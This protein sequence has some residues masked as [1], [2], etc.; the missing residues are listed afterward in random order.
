MKNYQSL[1]IKCLPLVRNLAFKMSYG[2][3]SLQDELICVGNEALCIAAMRFDDSKASFATYAYRCIEGSMLNAINTERKYESFD[4]LDD[5]KESN[6]NTMVYNSADRYACKQYLD[7]APGSWQVVD[8]LFNRA[9]LTE[10]EDDVLRSYY[11]VGR[12]K[13]STKDIANRYHRTVQ[14]VNVYRRNAEAKLRR[15][16]L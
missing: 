11:G 10:T 7:S 6:G 1:A 12:D 13:Q 4:G 5:D 9:E 15:T 3:P 14:M 8:S 16:S 2:N